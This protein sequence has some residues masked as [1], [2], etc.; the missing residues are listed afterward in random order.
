L[1]SCG[2]FFSISNLDGVPPVVF[3]LFGLAFFVILPGGAS[4]RPSDLASQTPKK[5]EIKRGS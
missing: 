1:Y 5:D 2:F 3:G 4:G